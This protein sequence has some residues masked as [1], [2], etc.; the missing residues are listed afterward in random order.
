[1]NL[2]AD[3]TIRDNTTIIRK[4][5]EKEN[6]LTTGRRIIS[7]KTAADYSLSKNLNIRLYYDRQ[8]T[9]PQLSVPF[10]TSNSNFGFS[11]RDPLTR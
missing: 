5:T 7:I 6:Q 4:M 8:I 2:R 3:F 11:L 1:L 9:K 10:P